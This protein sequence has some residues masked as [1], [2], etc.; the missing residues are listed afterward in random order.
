MEAVIN[1]G[2]KAAARGNGAGGGPCRGVPACLAV[3]PSPCCAL[4]PN[5]AQ[6]TRSHG[7]RVSHVHQ[8]WVCSS[9]EQPSIHSCDAAAVPK[10]GCEAT[11]A[12]PAGTALGGSGCGE[13]PLLPL[14]S[15]SWN[16]H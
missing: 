14:C 13:Q 1:L 3:F 6:G 11:P 4:A 2:G 15:G 12:P 8:L 7:A 9:V 5:P 10:D 16:G